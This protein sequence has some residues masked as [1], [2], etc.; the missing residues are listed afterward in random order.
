MWKEVLDVTYTVLARRYRSRDFEEVVGQSPISETL[1]RAVEQ[2][3]TAH[4]YLFCG[5]RG[6]GKTTLARIFA[7][8][9]NVTDDL[10]D[11]EGI[12]EA[13]MRGDDLDVI[14]IDGASNR[15][16]QEARDLIAGAGLSPARCRCRI[17]IIDEV[18]MLTTESFNTLLKTMEEPPEHVKFI[19][20]TTEPHKVLPTIQSRCQRFDFKPIPRRLIAEHL[21]NVVKQEGVEVDEAA[22]SRVA[23]LGAGSMRDALSVMDRLLATGEGHITLKD[24]ESTLG[25]PET[26]LVEAVVDGIASAEP[27]EAL[28]AA[29]ALLQSGASIE[30][31]LSSLTDAFRSMLIVRSCGPDTNV[32]DLAEEQRSAVA[33]R[34]ARFDLPALVHG[35]AVCESIARQGRLGAS[36]RALFDA[37][38]VRLSLA[39]DMVDPVA[40]PSP[41]S[42]GLKKKSSSEQKRKIETPRLKQDSAPEQ[43]SSRVQSDSSESTPS[44]KSPTK[45]K[46]HPK[47]LSLESHWRA[48]SE[49]TENAAMVA[50]VEGVEV[51][52]FEDTCIRLR[53]TQG[54]V[55]SVAI[56]RISK[57]LSDASGKVIQVIDETPSMT[58]DDR[59]K[60][61]PDAVADPRV[62]LARSLFDAKVVELKPNSEKGD[63]DDV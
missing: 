55:S 44:A 52:A 60:A 45:K 4:A 12:A 20:C 61:D 57:R 34:A 56:E 32:L 10:E 24:V 15:G 47:E 36:A 46:R 21:A 48:L 6:V 18:H 7:R 50:A 38:I 42:A 31:A 17:Y 5:T 30:Q 8:A 41:A 1:R 25:L 14:E 59:P 54:P 53:C 63:G 49:S 22:L 29:D 11:A 16:V 39:T 43:T 9:I 51:V 33:T 35:I 26:V 2:D 19:L 40:V 37:A 23:E 58:A 62:D 13:I 3:R 28:Q 27:S